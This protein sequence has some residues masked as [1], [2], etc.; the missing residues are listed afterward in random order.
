MWWLGYCILGKCT[1][2]EK[3]NPESLY[4]DITY[5]LCCHVGYFGLIPMRWELRDNV[6]EIEKHI[7]RR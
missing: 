1:T 3:G 2:A 7:I 5:A 4:D 6:E